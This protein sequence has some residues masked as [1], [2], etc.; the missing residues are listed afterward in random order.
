MVS[1]VSSAL[2][3]TGT[4]SS[5][6]ELHVEGRIHGDIQCKLLILSETAEINGNAIAEEVIVKGRFVGCIRARRVQL[7]S[8]CRVEGD[9]VHQELMIQEGAFFE[10]ASQPN[11][12]PIDGRTGIQLALSRARAEGLLAL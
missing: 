5:E 10:G 4:L 11:I 2:F 12:D 7:D 3:I 6:G 8:E 9:I 1:I